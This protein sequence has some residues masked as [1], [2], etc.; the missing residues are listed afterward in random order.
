MHNQI[1]TTGENMDIVLNIDFDAVA[2]F[3]MLVNVFFKNGPCCVFRI[4]D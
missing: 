3:V 1:S 2:F 4:T